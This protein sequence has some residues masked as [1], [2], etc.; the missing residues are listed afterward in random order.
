V[1]FGCQDFFRVL[2]PVSTLWGLVKGCPMQT[3]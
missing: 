1:V 2:G 3:T